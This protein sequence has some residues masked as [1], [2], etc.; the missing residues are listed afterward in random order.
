[1]QSEVSF[2]FYNDCLGY[3]CDNC[4]FNYLEHVEAQESKVICLPYHQGAEELGITN[5]LGTVNSDA[6]EPC[7][8]RVKS[9][10]TY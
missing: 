2:H 10:N 5:K 4:Y 1:M 9:F 6:S 7:L 3:R 8:K